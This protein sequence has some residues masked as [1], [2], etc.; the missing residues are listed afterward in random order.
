MEPEEDAP[1]LSSQPPATTSDPK[2]ENPH[3]ILDIWLS[4]SPSFKYC[5]ALEL[6][7]ELAMM[8]L[9][10]PMVSLLEQAICTRYYH[11]DISNPD[12]CKIAPIQR[13]LA[14]VRGWTASFETLAA[15]IVALPVG[16][17]ADRRDQRRVFMVI[18]A[19]M[20]MSLT[21][22]L[23]IAT[24]P[25]L[26][27]KLVWASS[28][29]LLIGGGRYAAE[30]LLAAMVAKV[31][32]EE[33]RTRGLYH[34]YSCFIFSELIG[35]PIASFTADVSPWLPFAVSYLLLFSAFPLLAMMPTDHNVLDSTPTDSEEASDVNTPPEHPG[36]LLT[37]LHASVDQFRLLKFMFSSRNMRLAAAIFLV[38]TSRG[39]SL[40]ALIQYASARFGW[41]LSK[42]SCEVAFV[43]LVLF[44]LV[45]PA[46]I[47]MVSR[48]LKPANQTLN[49]GI[50]RAS[51]SLLSTGSLL[52]AFSWSSTFL[53][54]ATMIYA[55]GFGAR[56]TLLSL[57]TSWI[58]PERAATLYSA[59]FLVE[60]F[61]MLG[62]E[63]LIQSLLG[64]GIGLRDPLK[65][66]PFICTGLFY[67]IGLTCAFA[68]KPNLS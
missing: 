14:E 27:I 47:S 51:L 30:M 55:L 49:L 35:P 59:V 18:I 4:F 39:I 50:V 54:I 36:V 9:T 31:C 1:L 44:F 68:M 65:G 62:G 10:V 3:P 60:Q 67:L 37:V 33:T 26:P 43:N 48:Y 41:K 8:I 58:D 52:V 11:G 53:I 5:I 34:F 12:L 46:L 19:G 17:I 16:L 2:N 13:T 64:V 7:C 38:G 24:N 21:W 63:P 23:V 32:N 6:L 57:I 15:I 29:F 40:R 42:A 61:G 25:K 20:L 56:S 22:T 28:V 45:M 66:L